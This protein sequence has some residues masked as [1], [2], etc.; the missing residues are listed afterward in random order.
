MPR[1]PLTHT[2][3]ACRCYQSTRSRP[4][5]SDYLRGMHWLF[6]A[7]CLGVA[8]SSSTKNESDGGGAGG[9]AGADAGFDLAACVEEP[10]RAQCESCCQ[11][12]LPDQVSFYLSAV[13]Y[14]K[15]SN[16]WCDAGCAAGSPG[17]EACVKGGC[18][19]Y[20]CKTLATCALGCP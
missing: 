16:V 18:E 8:C 17:Y 19:A 5:D 2:R 9:T 3:Y 4:H 13:S 20:P 10:T 1:S 12:H 15:G 14:C 11:K 6:F 7:A